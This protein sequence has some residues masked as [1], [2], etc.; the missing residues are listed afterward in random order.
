MR[1]EYKNELAK[2]RSEN[3]KDQPHYVEALLMAATE[4]MDEHPD[5]YD[6]ACCCDECCTY[7]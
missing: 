3:E 4:K 5:D 6:D 7:Q 2:W 1:D